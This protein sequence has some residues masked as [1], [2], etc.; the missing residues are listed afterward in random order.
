MNYTEHAAL[1]QAIRHALQQP[2]QPEPQHHGCPSGC[3]ICYVRSEFKGLQ[4]EKLTD[5]RH[6]R[7]RLL[8]SEMHNQG[9]GG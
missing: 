6:D 5:A 8:A 1:D 4:L 9:N 2:G 3:P 7:V